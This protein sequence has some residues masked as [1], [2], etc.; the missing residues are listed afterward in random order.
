M[1]FFMESNRGKVY[2][3]EKSRA[4]RRF[5]I[6]IVLAA[7]LI[8][9][10]FIIGR[11][12][13]ADQYFT[14]ENIRNLV[15][16]TGI[17]GYVLFILIFAVG[18]LLHI[19]GLIF[20]AA[21]VYAFGK[22]TGLV[23]GLIGAIVAV[24]VSF[25]VIRTVGGKAFTRIEKPWAVNMMNRLDKMPIRIVIVLRLFLIMHPSLN[26]ALALTS[27]S[28]RDY[29]IGSAIGLVIPVSAF[30]IFFDWLMNIFL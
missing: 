16:N 12:T 29:L 20:I 30:V 18:E 27:I 6:R 10:L 8:A 13:G 14:P 22:T 1:V 21:G 24:S 26:Y 2:D 19:F 28:F 9:I 17:W 25:I 7:G 11:L 3:G 15:Q 5:H 23:I 4:S